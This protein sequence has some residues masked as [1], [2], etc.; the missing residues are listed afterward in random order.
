MC[1]QRNNER[2]SEFDSTRE[3]YKQINNL[4]D[5]SRFKLAPVHAM[6]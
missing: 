1:N 2:S 4:P 6:S 3:V 5:S